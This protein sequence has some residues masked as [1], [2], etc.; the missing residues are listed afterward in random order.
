M[1]GRSPQSGL[2]HVLLV[3]VGI[4]SPSGELIGTA[5]YGRQATQSRD[6]APNQ[7]LQ[8]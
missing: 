7:Q 8:Y 1:D 4:Q 3:D 6:N 2:R 5:H